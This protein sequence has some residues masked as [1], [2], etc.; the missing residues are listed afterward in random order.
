MDKAEVLDISNEQDILNE[1]DKFIRGL[2]SGIHAIALDFGYHIKSTFLND[3]VF[4]LRNNISYRLSSSRFHF[5]LLFNELKQIQ[6][7]HDSLDY[8]GDITNSPD[9]HIEIDKCHLSYIID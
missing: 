1:A 6:L 3:K 2:D 7:K 8:A 9:W 4:D 5:H